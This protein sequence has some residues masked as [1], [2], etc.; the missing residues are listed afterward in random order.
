MGKHQGRQISH[1]DWTE[2]FEDL[3]FWAVDAEPF[4]SNQVKVVL[5]RLTRP[6]DKCQILCSWE[7]AR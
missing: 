5:D 2:L 6:P 7:G 1:G 4:L 3:F